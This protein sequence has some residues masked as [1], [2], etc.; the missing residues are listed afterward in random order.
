M[1]LSA[2]VDQ[3][4]RQSETWIP[5]IMAYGSRLLLALVTL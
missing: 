4:V 3:L 1:D 2:E 5:M